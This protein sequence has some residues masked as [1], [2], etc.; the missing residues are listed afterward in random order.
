MT[1][2][3]KAVSEKAFYNFSIP[4]GAKIERVRDG[5]LL[6]HDVPLMAEGVWESMQG[7]KA[8]FTA[9]ALE[10]SAKVWKD[11]GLWLKHPGGA[12]RAVTDL[13]G[14][15]MNPRYEAEGAAGAPA[16][17][18]DLY[19]PCK[20]TASRDAAELVQIPEEQGGI[21]SISAETIL[22]MEYDAKADENVVIR[23][24]N[25]GAALVRRGACEVCKLPAYEEGEGMPKDKVK[26][27]HEEGEEEEGDA[28]PGKDPTA[29]ALE[30]IKSLLE[31]QGKFI[32]ALHEKMCN[33]QPPEGE[34]DAGKEG[35][36]PAK[37]GDAKVAY[38]A[39]TAKMKAEYEAKI[40]TLEAQAA[41]LA[42]KPA[43]AT[44]AQGAAD[45][46]KP[47]ETPIIRRT[48]EGVIEV[49]RR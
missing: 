21:K 27:S 31:E 47:I 37:E 10:K 36:A 11:N 15:C 42:N 43:P 23:F 13:V 3:R 12:P 2:K 6:I 28:P 1:I 39:E 29:A 40:A 14:S 45:L 9:E 34:P 16:E 19:M 8:R 48:S 5:G 49:K 26:T 33:E 22:E 30:G 32:K 46:E 4:E 44:V 18:V 41:K 17:M 25:T 7:V 38:E 20:T 35:G 24:E